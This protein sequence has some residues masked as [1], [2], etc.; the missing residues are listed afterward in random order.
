MRPGE[1]APFNY[2][3]LI[4]RSLTR[5][6]RVLDYGCGVGGAVAYGLSRGVDIWGADTFTGYYSDWSNA[7]LPEAK[8]RILEIES[9]RASF[10]DHNFD[11]V[12]SNQVLEHVTDPEAV[13]ADMHRLLRP[14][15]LFIAAFPVREA[16]YEGHIGLYFAHRFK[17][18]SRWRHAYF[19]ICHRIGFGLYRSNLTRAQWLAHLERTLDEACFYYPKRRLI[20]GIESTF[21]APTKDIAADYMRARLGTIIHDLP[22]AA[23]PIL[24]LIYHLRAGQILQVVKPES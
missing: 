5:A 2:R 10:P 23:N 12:F 7:I 14:G 17:A 4:E 22:S 13:V 3:F 1:C 6:G 20:A 18:G 16:W 15:G 21:G 9:G 8:G 19:D 11:V 24:R